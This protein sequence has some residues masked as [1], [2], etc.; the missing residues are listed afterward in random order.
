ALWP[1]EVSREY[2]LGDRLRCPSGL[3]GAWQELRD[4]GGGALDR[5][6]DAARLLDVDDEGFA[7][8]VARRRHPLTFDHHRRLV[9]LAAEPDE[10]VGGDVRVLG[11]A[12]EHA[13]ER[14]VVLAEELRPAAR[15]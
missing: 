11:V 7:L 12:G 9:H 8:G 6:P 2:E 10:D 15:L 13:L 14:Q 3:G 5:L 1:A 4:L